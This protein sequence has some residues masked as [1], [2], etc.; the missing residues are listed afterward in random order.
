MGWSKLAQSPH[1]SFTVVYSQ[2]WVGFMS[3]HFLMCL[4]D[5]PVSNP[6]SITPPLKLLP[7]SQIKSPLFFF[8]MSQIKSAL[9]FSEHNQHTKT[10]DVKE[11]V[12]NY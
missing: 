9:S 7:T 6:K 11:V 3:T 12:L 4:L 1:D 5:Q 2:I 8:G 10:R